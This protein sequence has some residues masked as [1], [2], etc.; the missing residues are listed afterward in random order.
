MAHRHTEDTWLD[1]IEVEFQMLE[2]PLGTPARADLEVRLR[3]LEREFRA[4]TAA[5]VTKE[6]ARAALP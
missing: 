4:A 5:L 1:L 6:F 2:C 3:Q